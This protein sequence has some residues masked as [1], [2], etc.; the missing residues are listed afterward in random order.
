MRSNG[1]N[2]FRSILFAAMLT[3]AACSRD[4]PSNTSVEV[5]PLNDSDV[6][7]SAIGTARADGSA[8]ANVIAPGGRVPSTSGDR[9]SATGAA[10]PEALQGRWALTPDDCTSARGDAKGLLVVSRD[11]LRFYESVA[12]P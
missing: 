12:K 3:A 2:P 4:G 5:R 7:G 1:M 10:I 6:A 11:E 9:A 8:P